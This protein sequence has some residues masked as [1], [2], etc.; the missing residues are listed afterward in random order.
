MDLAAALVSEPWRARSYKTT[1]VAVAMF[2][3]PLGL[4]ARNSV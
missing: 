1:S 3:R 4:N 2:L